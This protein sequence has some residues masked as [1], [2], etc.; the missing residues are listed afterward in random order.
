MTEYIK[1]AT[2]IQNSTYT[3]DFIEGLFKRRRSSGVEARRKARAS[4]GVKL[5]V[6]I[7]FYKDAFIFSFIT[8]S[9]FHL[10]FS[11]PTERYHVEQVV[12]D[13]SYTLSML[14]N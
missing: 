10:H 12:H 1:R 11:F 9:T 3:S 14:P 6:A 13:N 7:S 5:C 8:R 2:D 4:S